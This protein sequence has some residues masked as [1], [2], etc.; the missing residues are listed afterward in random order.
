MTV[1][2]IRQALHAAL[3]LRVPIFN[4]QTNAREKVE[5]LE[6]YLAQCAYK[7]ADCE[8]ALYWAWEAEK[9][10]RDEWD[11]IQGWEN[12]LPSKARS[13]PTEAHV[14]R[15]KARVKPETYA[16]LREVKTLIEGLD[17]QCKRLTRDEETCS[18]RYTL[19]VGG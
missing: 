14:T 2:E 11:G 13:R 10:L 18:R 4:P 7:R 3:P 12:F 8:A 17:R 1:E 19:L 16:G 9:V 6:D 5:A 15:A